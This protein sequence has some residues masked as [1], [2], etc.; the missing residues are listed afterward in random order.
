M[1]FAPEFLGTVKGGKLVAENV[2][3]FK[4]AFYG[5]EGK[6][7]RVKVELFRNR[8]SSEQNKYYHAVVVPMVGEAMGEADN[9][10]VHEIL[11]AKFNYE[12]LVI[13][14]EELLKPLSTAKLDTKA[15]SEYI[16]KIRTWAAS[17]LGL[18]IPDPG[19][20]SE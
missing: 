13:G 7:V 3:Q 2:R 4:G 19:E 15:F 6:R 17:F 20:V 9:E 10:T 1:K 8:R 11:K 14:A 18:Y 5:F 12:I 16:E